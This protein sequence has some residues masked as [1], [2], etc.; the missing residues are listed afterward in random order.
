M[1]TAADA[2]RHAL[3]VNR[4][5]S[6]FVERTA[7]EFPTQEALD[8]YLKDHPDADKSKHTVAKPAGAK[9]PKVKQFLDYGKKTLDKFQTNVSEHGWKGQLKQL[10]DVGARLEKTLNEVTKGMDE[11]AAR[12][13]WDALAEFQHLAEKGEELLPDMAPRRTVNVKPAKAEAFIERAK[14][15]LADLHKALG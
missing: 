8:A 14:E 11:K 15:Q 2:F 7:M 4:V 9:N 6:R 3:T 1:K 10:A 5:A 13:M 12:K